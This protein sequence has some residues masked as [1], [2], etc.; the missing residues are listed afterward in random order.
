MR[1]FLASYVNHPK[2]TVRSAAIGALGTLGDP[3]SISV[4][5]AFSSSSDKRIERAANQALG[6]LR[7]SKPTAPKEL[8]ELRK[9]MAAM[10]KESKKVL[11]ELK[12]LRKQLK[13][14]E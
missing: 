10:K 7:E 3:K 14:Q 5:E 6:K 11:S 12:E 9:E 2:S 13:A 1:D 8:I 4:L